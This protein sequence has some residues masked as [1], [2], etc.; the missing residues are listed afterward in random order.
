ME[1]AWTEQSLWAI[2]RHKIEHPHN[3]KSSK[4]NGIKKHLAELENNSEAEFREAEEA[5]E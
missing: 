4:V 2:V 3:K 1:P 5:K